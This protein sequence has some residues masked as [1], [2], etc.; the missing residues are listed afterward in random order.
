MLLID[1][2]QLFISSII[3]SKNPDSENFIKHVV[4]NSLRAN[5]KKFKDYGEVVLCSDSRNYWRKN[6]FPHYKAHRKE[7][8]DKS[9]L[10]WDLIF[11]SINQLKDDIREH[12]PYKLLEV[13]GAEADDIIGTLAPRH[14]AHEPIII[15]SS[16]K[17]F[18]QLQK[19][20][21]VKQYNPMLNVFVT[22]K[23]PVK[24]LKEKIIRGDAGDGIPN[25]LSNDD[26]FITKTRQKP[27]STKKL[28][29]WLTKDPSSFLNEEEL[30][31]F[32]RNQILI[33]FDY[34]PKDIKEAIVHS[35]ENTQKG[36]NSKLY[37]YFVTNRMMNLLEVIEDFSTNKT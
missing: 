8:R 7:S 36:N 20:P 28:E 1:S 27:I 31:N 12:F 4:L 37:K 23:D 24:D 30:R 22:S 6:I 18:V 13:P 2:N 3:Q 15:I 5:V 33:D 14:S 32:N 26:V 29:E 19:Y 10:N 21:N 16:D 11:S 25:T 9:S 17:D 35:Y 34:I